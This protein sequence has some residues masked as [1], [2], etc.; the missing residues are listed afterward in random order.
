M[1]KRQTHVEKAI[2]E[3]EYQIR[4]LELAREHLRAQ[5]KPATPKPAKRPRAIAVNEG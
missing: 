4:S 5:L 3:I 1:S 2:A